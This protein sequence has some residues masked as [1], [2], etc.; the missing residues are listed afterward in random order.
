MEFRNHRNIDQF[1]V[2][3]VNQVYLKP[4]KKVFIMDGPIGVGKSTN[5][6]FDA[7]YNVAQHV[8]PVR[9][10]NKE[11]RRSSW[12][13]ARESENSA[14]N[15]LYEIF[16][17]GRFPAAILYDKG[18]PVKKSGIN[19]VIVTI[20]HPLADGT[21]LSM[22]IEC[23]GFRDDKSLGRLKSRSFLGGIAPEM[24]T[25]P[26]DVIELL[27]ERCGGRAAPGMLVQ[28]A[29]NGQM[30]TLSGADP[31]TMVFADMNIPERPHPVYDKLYDNPQLS[32]SEYQIITPPSPI[33]AKHLEQ[34]TPEQLE[35]FPTTQF[36]GKD[37]VWVPN[38]DVY[39]MTAH[40]EEAILENGN[41]VLE[42]GQLKTIPYSGYNY[43]LNRVNRDESYVNRLIVGKPNKLGGKAAIYKNFD[44]DKHQSTDGYNKR[45]THLYWLRSGYLCGLDILPNSEHPRK[46]AYSLL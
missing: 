15:T 34:A 32:H 41:P 13:I 35:R 14:V 4:S 31:L 9:E 22:K 10:G 46:A 1:F 17:R 42:N 11:V 43:W 6:T 5:F 20:E 19:P 44:K 3:A 27:V 18:G 33:K 28:K 24:Q 26:F 36:Q 39:W 40:Y 16:E 29:I 23:Y 30:H 8:N 12:V 2:E 25:M 7:P 37:V 38:P 45:P 21:Y